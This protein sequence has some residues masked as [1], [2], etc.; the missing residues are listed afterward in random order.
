MPAVIY[1]LPD[2]GPLRRGEILSKVIQIKVGTASITSS[3][4][5]TLTPVTHQV[6]IVLNQDCDLEGD[7]RAR[8]S[9]DTGTLPNIL[10]A[11]AYDAGE[12]LRDVGGSDIR[13]RIR[14]NQDERYQYLREVAP[15]CDALKEG[16]PAL[17][18][19]FK[20]CFTIPTEEL[21]Y[22]MSATV[23]VWQK[24]H[25]SEQMTHRRCRLTSTYAAGLADRFFRF[26]A[27]VA[28]PEP[29]YLKE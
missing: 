16:L 2:D 3:K 21:Y 28:L 17:V 20:R 27:R 23:H 26:H 15:Q 9:G 18:I 6:A 14:Q 5:P 7:F 22:R 19:D 8:R 29:H 11:E 12:A 10:F 24:E 1:E 25:D 13:R 4:P